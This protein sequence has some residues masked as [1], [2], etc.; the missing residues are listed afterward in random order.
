MRCHWSAGGFNGSLVFTDET[1]DLE[2]GECAVADSFVFGI[3]PNYFHAAGTILLSGRNVT[4]HDDKNAPRVAVI[5]QE[6][7]RKVFGSVTNATGRYFKQPDGTRT[8]VVGVVED[9]KYVRLV[10][11][12]QPRCFSR[13]CNRPRARH[14]LMRSS[15][16]PG[17]LV[18]AIRNTVRVS[19]RVC[20]FTSNH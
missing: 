17:Q 5:N 2:V 4:W 19:M 18:A 15:R 7:A 12:Q 8:Q 16:D 1:A 11:E 3:S 20:L 6:F 14:T 10:E 13:C 9:G